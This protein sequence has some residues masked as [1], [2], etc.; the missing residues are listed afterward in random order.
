MTKDLN[1]SSKKQQETSKGGLRGWWSKRSTKGKATIGICCIG[2]ILM[3]IIG[4]TLSP[5]ANTANTSSDNNS[6]TNSNTQTTSTSDN[7]PTPNF[8]V[9]TSKFYL[10]G[11]FTEG[12]NSGN[13]GEASRVRLDKTDT[14][15]IVTE[16]SSKDLYKIE[17]K[18]AE[19]YKTINGVTVTKVP[20]ALSVFFEKNGK[21]YSIA[22]NTVNAD[23]NTSPASETSENQQYIQDIIGSMQNA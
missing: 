8:S 14:N 19:S 18:N 1:E 12:F 21:Y 20:N 6:T 3:V 13:G 7:S 15:I 22:V 11:G 5:D 16:Y 9:G 23:G 10:S 17:S 2:L 4:G